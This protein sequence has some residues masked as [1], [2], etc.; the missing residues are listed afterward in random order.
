MSLTPMTLEEIARLD[1]EALVNRMD[2][3]I[4]GS[5]IERN[6]YYRRSDQT[7]IFVNQ[8]LSTKWFQTHEEAKRRKLVWQCFDFIIQL[9]Y[10]YLACGSFNAILD[11][12]R[13]KT[14]GFASPTVQLGISATSQNTIVGSRIAFERLMRLVYYA[15]TG[16]D[17]STSDTFSNFKKWILSLGPLHNLFYVVPFLVK[18]RHYDKRFRTAEVH[19]G[20]VLKRHI[21]QLREQDFDL[22]NDILDLL[23]LLA[24]LFPRVIELFNETRPTSVFGR[25]ESDLHWIKPYLTQDES[26]LRKIL[27]K[28]DSELRET[29]SPQSGNLGHSS[30]GNIE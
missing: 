13:F 18:V 30:S 27:D 19:A 7:D 3:I 20:S 2:A 8:L 24:N 5:R 6:P 9:E 25:S 10:V 14:Q 11:S 21:I 29:A 4:E 16:S 15:F 23:N 22:A 26:E 12:P 28:I 17:L 1:V